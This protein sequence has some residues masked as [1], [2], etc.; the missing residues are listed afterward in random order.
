MTSLTARGSS[1]TTEATMNRADA[2]PDRAGEQR[3]DVVDEVGVGGTASGETS[4]PVRPAYAVDAPAARPWAPEEAAE[5]RLELTDGRRPPPQPGVGAAVA[6]A[7]EDV[8]ER[9]R[10]DVLG[11]RPAVRSATGRRTGRR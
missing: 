6:E 2:E 3:L 10:L 7:G 11:G 4:A 8:D 1:S 5:Q 9:R